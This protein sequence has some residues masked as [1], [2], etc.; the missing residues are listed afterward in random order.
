MKTKEKNS[1]WQIGDALLSREDGRFI[2]LLEIPRKHDGYFIAKTLDRHSF[3]TKFELR[4]TLI[5]HKETVFK[6]DWQVL[7]A[8]QND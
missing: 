8:N 4:E 1:N 5:C 2:I 7:E 3:D 6:S